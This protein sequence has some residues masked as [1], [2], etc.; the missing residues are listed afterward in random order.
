MHYHLEVVM[1]PTGDI[2]K[3][4]ESILAQFDENDTENS[5]TFWDWWAIGGRWAGVKQQASFPQDKLDTF[6]Q[7]LTDEGVTVSGIQC[8]K[9]ELSPASQI[10]KV[11]A[12]WQ[13]MFGVT[14]P[15]TLFRH[16]NA[17]GESLGGDVCTLGDIA[18]VTASR[19]I[20]AGPAYGGGVEA[21]YMVEQEYWNGVTHV[22]ST[23]DGQ[24]KSA[25]KLWTDK[26]ASYGDEWRA[27][28]TPT[29]EWLVVT[30]DYHS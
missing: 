5:H 9:Q 18:N 29:D 22:Q 14:G 25:V 13:E 7:W 4:L 10:P 8:G 23:W 28:H 30:V 1:P 26:L 11:D 6:R 16:S 17:R 12:K 20:I 24:V 3:A 21:C 19:V 15:C 2:Q 27:A